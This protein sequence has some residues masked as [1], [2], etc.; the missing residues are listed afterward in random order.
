MGF[1][2]VSY[3]GRVSIIVIRNFIILLKWR[4]DFEK[5]SSLFTLWKYL[6][7]RQRNKWVD[8]IRNAMK[9][10]IYHPSMVSTTSTD[11]SESIDVPRGRDQRQPS[12][13]HNT[14]DT[15]PRPGA[16][17][18]RV[19][20]TPAGEFEMT[21]RPSVSSIP[22]SAHALAM[23]NRRSREMVIDWTFLILF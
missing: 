10:P 19:N 6:F 23:Q 12:S 14:A 11:S 20:T 3:L 21:K 18:K 13:V 9:E 7:R 2:S 17:W 8:A 1:R 4:T 5:I 16:D 15:A 22:S